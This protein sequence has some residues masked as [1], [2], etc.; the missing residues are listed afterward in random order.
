[1]VELLNALAGT[2]M[3][4]V[5]VVELVDDDGG[6]ED[7]ICALLEDEGCVALG[8]EDVTQVQ[9][10]YEGCYLFEDAGSQGFHVSA[11]LE[12]LL[13]ALLQEV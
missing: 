13:T 4:E 9:G 12:G 11:E 3:W 8:A 2:D 5:W 7:A 1:M 6:V 10:F